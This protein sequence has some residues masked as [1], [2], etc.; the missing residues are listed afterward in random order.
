MGRARLGG[1]EALRGGQQR[2]RRALVAHDEVQLHRERREVAD[3]REG[4]WL[5]AGGGPE[6]RDGDLRGHAPGRGGVN[7]MTG[8]SLAE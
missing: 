7:M 4:G 8:S 6:A 2:Q 5:A 1:E 3:E